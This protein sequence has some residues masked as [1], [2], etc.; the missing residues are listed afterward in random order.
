MTFSFSSLPSSFLLLILLKFLHCVSLYDCTFLASHPSVLFAVS[1]ILSPHTLMSICFL[2]I[3]KYH[4]PQHHYDHRT[5]LSWI[6]FNCSFILCIN[7]RTHAR[8]HTRLYSCVGLSL[9]I[10]TYTAWKQGKKCYS[11]HLSTKCIT[12]HTHS[13][14]TNTY[15]STT[16]WLYFQRNKWYYVTTYKT[17]LLLHRDTHAY[18]IRYV[19]EGKKLR[20]L[21]SNG[22]GKT[23]YAIHDTPIT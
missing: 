4:K 5:E 9:R 23:T 19:L 7:A 10:T 20:M 8:T 11:E 12:S 18:H 1:E 17:D 14:S 15:S 13:I 16:A 22:F 2:L 3:L 6:C 21:D